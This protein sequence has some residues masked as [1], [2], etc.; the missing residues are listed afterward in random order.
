ME[1]LKKMS[2]WKAFV[3]LL[4][5][6]LLAKWC[7]HF[8][9]LSII[10]HLV[11]ALLFGMLIQVSDP[12]HN[13]VKGGSHFIANKFLRLGIILIGFKLNLTLLAQNGVKT[14]GL[15]VLV[16]VFTV[17][18]IYIIAARVF[19]IDH[20]LALL[21]ASGCGICGAA[22]V[23]GLSPMVDSNEDDEVIAV[24]IVA[25]LGTL[26]TLL[27]VFLRTHL[28]ISDVQYGVWA[29]LS[30][31]EIAHAVAAGNSA[32]EEALNIATIVKLSRVLMLAPYSL[33]LAFF[34]NKR[35]DLSDSK[36]FK[37][38]IPWF[39][40]GFIL[41]SALGTYIEFSQNLLKCLIDIG[42][43]LLGMAMAA[44]GANVHFRV[45]FKKGQ[46]M[47]FVAFI[48]SVLLSFLSYILSKMLF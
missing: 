44:L 16:I 17:T 4:A 10:G 38:P 22:A 28:E 7:A 41:A 48:G 46:K 12:L 24:A 14:L 35:R 15:A 30:L 29:G 25:I 19:K 11:I 47:F 23:L 42:Y 3:P 36:D 45:I 6:S 33:L 13:I 31:H 18:T 20:P 5:M 43:I 1:I 39:M 37:I 40:L 26:F 2:F 27:L 9:G 34:V 32:G 8:P 21:S